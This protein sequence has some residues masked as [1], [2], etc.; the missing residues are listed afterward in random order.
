MEKIKRILDLSPLQQELVEKN[1][2]LAFFFS[3]HAMGIDQDEALSLAM[4]GLS[5][6]AMTFRDGAG[7]FGTWAALAI[8]SKFRSYKQAVN[9]LKRGGDFFIVS[10]EDP[11][12]CNDSYSIPL[13]IADTVID[14]TAISASDSVMTEQDSVILNEVIKLLDPRSLDI[15]R[16]RFGLGGA[17][18]LTLEQV[19]KIHGITRERTRQL[20]KLAINRLKKIHGCGQFKLSSTPHEYEDLSKDNA[21]KG[22]LE[23][24]GPTLPPKVKATRRRWKKLWARK[25]A[26]TRPNPIKV[27][28][29]PTT[30]VVGP[31]RKLELLRVLLHS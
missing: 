28:Y 7:K 13:T 26:A 5:V 31:G 3:R 21:V 2:G 30:A 24:M 16:R 8:K 11:V 29:V 4:E 18:P 9:S 20:E 19:G 25:R 27:D 6:A 14:E 23:K 1:I 12:L 15:L 22:K 17:D 10:M